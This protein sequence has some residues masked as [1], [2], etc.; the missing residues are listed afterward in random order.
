MV[1]KNSILVGR[2]QKKKI[3]GK[4]YKKKNLRQ[5][6]AYNTATVNHLPIA[7]DSQVFLWVIILLN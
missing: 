7:G 3:F 4:Y 1:A 5:Y 6:I 2:F